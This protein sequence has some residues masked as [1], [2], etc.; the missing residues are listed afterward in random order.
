M[1]IVSV[2]KADK[3][4]WA[5]AGSRCAEYESFDKFDEADEAGNC[6][7]RWERF[8]H[9]LT[10]LNWTTMQGAGRLADN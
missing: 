7:G 9:I 1:F 5:T 8:N 4:M 6:A 3:Y 2:R 10:K